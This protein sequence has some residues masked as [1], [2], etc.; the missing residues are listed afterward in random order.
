MSAAAGEEEAE[1]LRS[2]NTK[3]NASYENW[4][5]QLSP[6]TRAAWKEYRRLETLDREEGYLCYDDPEH[7]LYQDPEAQ[8]DEVDKAMPLPS[9][10]RGAG[11]APEE[12]S[13]DTGPRCRSIKDDGWD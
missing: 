2:L 6:R 5:A 12:P 8:W 1:T 3:L 9:P 4:Y 11:E 10:E 7:E 13:E